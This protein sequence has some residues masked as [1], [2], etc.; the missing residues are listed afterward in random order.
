MHLQV[1]TFLLQWAAGGLLFLWVTSRARLVGLGY[2]WLLRATYGV[3]AAASV[4]ASIASDRTGAGALV[5]E[6]GAIGVVVAVAGA[7]VVSV[8]RRRAG[9]SGQRALRERR[10]ARVAAMTG[11]RAGGEIGNGSADAPRAAKEFPPAVDLLA[12]LVGL[13]GLFGA[14]GAERGPP[15]VPPARLLVG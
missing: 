12:P 2:G 14:A 3:L 4:A 10:A 6:V 15:T 1:S 13:V 8:V 11:R 5:E 7:L 9:V